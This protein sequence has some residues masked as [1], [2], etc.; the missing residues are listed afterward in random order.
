MKVKCFAALVTVAMMM[1]GLS[2]VSQAAQPGAKMATEAAHGAVGLK[3]HG[4]APASPS[5]LEGRLLPMSG[6]RGCLDCM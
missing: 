2:L 3:M 1:V 6:N 4:K 5:G